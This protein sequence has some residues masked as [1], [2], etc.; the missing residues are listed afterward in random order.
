MTQTPRP[1]ANSADQILP[2]QL[3]SAL[4][5]GPEAIKLLS[6]DCFDTL[7]W[8]DV[9]AP[10]DVFSAL[11][12]IMT[13]QRV[14]AEANARKAMLTRRRRNEVSLEDIYTQA[15][16]ALGDADRSEERAKAIADELSAEAAVCY[17]FTPTIELIKTAK[18]RG[19]KSDPRVG[20]LSFGSRTA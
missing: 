1:L 19:L 8:R 5:R 12:D 11:P 16:P 10:S 7:L 4:E 15:F 3:P 14:A 6:L 9:H 2:H 17:A 20:H 13:Q 18:A